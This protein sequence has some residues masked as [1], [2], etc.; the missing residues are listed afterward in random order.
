[1]RSLWPI[2]AQSYRS[3]F[4]VSLVFNGIAKV[5]LFV[6]TVCIASI[7]GSNEKTDIY[8]FVYG[9][10]I[11]L[12]GLVS[13]IDIMVLVPESMRLREKEGRAAATAFL[14]FFLRIYALAGIIFVAVMYYFGT[15]IFGYFSRFPRPVIE[16]YG[17]YFIAGSFYFLLLVLTGYLNNI[18]NSLRFFTIPM[19]ISGLNSCMVIAGIFLLHRHFDV[20]SIFISGIIAFLISLVIQVSVMTKSAGWNFFTSKKP[21][22]KGI[23]KNILYA[24]MGQLT[25]LASSFLPLFLLSGFGNGVIS[26]MNY[27]KNVADIPSTL[28][29]SQAANVSGIKLNEEAARGDGEAMNGTFIN[30]TEM[31]VFFLVPAGCYM[32]VFAR[33]IVELFYQHGNFNGPTIDSV[34][35]FLQLLSLT[36]FSIG[37]N[38]IVSRI[39]IAVQAL[40]SAFFYQLIM[41][42]LLIGAIWGLTRA[43]GIYGYP[44]GVVLMN[45][46]NFLFMYTICRKLVPHIRYL[47]LMRFTGIILCINGVLSAG[48]FLLFRASAMA[49][50]PK[51]L[52]SFL[53]YLTALLTVTRLFRLTTV[54]T[55][56]VK[57]V[58]E[59]F[60]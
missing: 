16:A 6:L 53:L 58:K 24:E 31:L 55:A 39:F 50:V 36:L 1:M 20:L 35:R 34:A 32:F 42:L 40:R 30:V 26:M 23:G 54:F 41:N 44:Y 3:G 48:L 9:T 17:N 10:M 12:S 51:L 52:L 45:S 59:R 25:T 38:S 2:K 29:T 22:T 19:I 13:I 28:L 7:F 21:G 15:G 47:R 5:L 18:L 46:L 57:Y 27:G 37:V 11:L 14:N 49:V 43:Y 33:P 8:F 4:L 60:E 56:F